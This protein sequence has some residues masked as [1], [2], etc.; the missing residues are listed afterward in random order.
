MP[1]GRLLSWRVVWCIMRP[2]RYDFSGAFDDDFCHFT[3]LDGAECSDP[4]VSETCGVDGGEITAYKAKTMNFISRILFILLFWTFSCST[5]AF[6]ANYYSQLALSAEEKKY[7]TL[8]LLKDKEFAQFVCF[9][10]FAESSC[11]AQT[12]KEVI[13]ILRFGDAASE[14]NDS[15]IVFVE[16]SFNVKN[17]YTGF[18]RKVKGRYKFVSIFYNTSFRVTKLEPLTIQISLVTDPITESEEN[19]EFVFPKK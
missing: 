8:Q 6:E 17:R 11:E 5:F 2:F 3:Y 13:D 15:G 19:E 10:S 12:L 1:V 16:P 9:G 4:G 14:N 7:M 18:F